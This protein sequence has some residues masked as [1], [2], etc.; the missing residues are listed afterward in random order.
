[1][2][3]LVFGSL[4]YMLKKGT[5]K[6]EDRRGNEMVCS[7]HRKFWN[8]LSHG[9]PTPREEITFTAWP[10]IN[11]HSQISKYDQSIFCLPH[12]PNFSDIFDLCLHWA[13]VVRGIR[14]FL[15]RLDPILLK[16]LERI[17]KATIVKEGV[18]QKKIFRSNTIYYWWYT[19]CSHQTFI[20]LSLLRSLEISQGS[21][22]CQETTTNSTS[23]SEFLC[24]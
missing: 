14:L 23:L 8:S 6:T 18:S 1:M 9:L 13:S 11:S 2:R 24:L 10:K 22:S 16:C 15:F 12:W 7:F 4:C 3:L 19:R 21:L 5:Y 20:Y 17:R